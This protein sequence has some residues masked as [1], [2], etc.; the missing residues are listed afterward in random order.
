MCLLST[1]AYRC[2]CCRPTGTS[3]Q[4]KTR[5]AQASSSASPVDSLFASFQQLNKS[6]HQQRQQLR[7]EQLRAQQERERE[8]QLQAQ[9]LEQQQ[10]TYALL[11][12][13][14][15]PSFASPF[16]QSMGPAARASNS[17]GHKRLKL[18]SGMVELDSNEQDDDDFVV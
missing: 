3:I 14:G 1:L 18:S 9:L 4:P 16:Q 6:Q 12:N 5:Q 8:D 7:Q 13:A 10:A 11:F 15:L 17:R 2:A